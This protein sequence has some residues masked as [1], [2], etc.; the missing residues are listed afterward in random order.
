MNRRA[1]EPQTAL[2]REAQEAAAAFPPLLAQ[3]HQLARSVV[4]GTHGRR[5]AG[6]GEDFWQFRSALPGDGRRA[7]DWRR[8]ARG[9]SP[10]VRQREWQAAQ[11]V[12]LWIDDARA[13]DFSS[14][15][16][17]PTK[18][19]RASVLGLALAIL[20]LRGGERVGLIEDDDP[21][22][23]GQTQ[24]ERMLAQ[25]SA[26]GEGAEYGTPA[27][28]PLPRGSRA[29]FLSDFLGDWAAISRAVLRAADSCVTGAL[30]QILDPVEERF[31][32]DGRTRFLSMAGSIRFESMRARA[33]KRGYLDRL[34]ARREAL[35]DLGRQ[36][37]W[38]VLS[39]E[40]SEPAQPALMWLYRAL[41]RRR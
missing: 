15:A 5:Q 37:G 28:R 26:R 25:L 32:F 24:I 7:I 41:E 18:G 33:L 12:L 20:L 27:E 31:P 9:D 17:H 10:F 11:S 40:S 23:S 22:R 4:L 21:P 35:G 2:R 3:A 29:V 13:M 36:T 30:V 16:D 1:H 38:Q 6:Q 14:H 19:A 8:S 39:H 34:N